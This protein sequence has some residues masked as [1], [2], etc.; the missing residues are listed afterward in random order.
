MTAN[1]QAILDAAMQ[2]S[3]EERAQLAECLL[4]SLDELCA[5]SDD[6]LEAELRRRGDEC[7]RDP[8]SMIPWDVLKKERP[9]GG[10]V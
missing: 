8:G 1:Y 5:L 4:G 6:E 7:T 2:L 3:D 10:C 9:F